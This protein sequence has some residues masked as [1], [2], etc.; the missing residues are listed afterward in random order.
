MAIHIIIVLPQE[1]SRRGME[2][3]NNI[4]QQI[5]PQ[6]RIHFLTL[7]RRCTLTP[8]HVSARERVPENLANSKARR[9][10]GFPQP[11]P[12]HTP[13]TVP[14]EPSW[15]QWASEGTQFTTTNQQKQ[16]KAHPEQV[17]RLRRTRKFIL[18]Q[19]APLQYGASCAVLYLW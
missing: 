5:T 4:G 10:R 1:K 6:L 2:L 8:A 14:T 18:I 3:R 17:F 7:H 11:T 13:S 12:S 16:E 15:M 9:N 19:M